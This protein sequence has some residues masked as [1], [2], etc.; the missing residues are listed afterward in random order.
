MC[1]RKNKKKGKMCT[2]DSNNGEEV[3]S[4]VG[5]LSGIPLLQRTR[6]MVNGS[7]IGESHMNGELFLLEDAQ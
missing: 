4:N 2:S 1:N 3:S 6:G 5:G 7:E